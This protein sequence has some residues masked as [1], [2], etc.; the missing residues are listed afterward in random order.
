MINP[1][2]RRGTWHVLLVMRFVA[3]ILLLAATAPARAEWTADLYG[4]GA[5]TP[6]SD[7]TMVINSPGGRADHVFHDVQWDPSIEYG[8]RAGYWLQ[9]VPWLGFAADLFRFDANVP[10]Q[11]V[12]TTISGVT[13]PANLQAIDFSIVALGLD[14][15]ARLQLMQSFEYPRGRLQPY[16]T[17]GPA[18]FRVKVTNRANSEL[19]TESATDTAWGYKLG[20]GA[21][22]QIGRNAAIFAEYRYTHFHAEPDLHGNITGAGVP[23]LFDLDT[24][25]LVAGASFSF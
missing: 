23:L 21:S 17:G 1:W 16:V 11:S 20:A 25:H 14:A 6:R 24:H 9:S 5:H 13:V 8:A 7:F 19:T 22:W 2:N 18:L 10:A 3:L 4:G 12:A 15:K